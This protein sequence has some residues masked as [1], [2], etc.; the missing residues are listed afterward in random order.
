MSLIEKIK[1]DY[2][3]PPGWLLEEYL[4]ELEWS[5]AEFGRRCD[6]SSKT[7]CQ[8]IAGEAPIEPA[9]ALQFEKV[10]D[11]PAHVWLNMESNYRLFLARSREEEVLDS[12][13]VKTWYNSFPIKELEANRIIPKATDAIDGARFLLVFFGVGSVTAWKRKVASQ[14]AMTRHTKEF[15]SSN[16]AVSVWLRL[17]EIS[18]V[19]Q[20]CTP[21][22]VS[23]FR[24]V[25]KE[26]R[27]L[28]S[29]NAEE[30]IPRLLYLCNQAGVAFTIV[31]PLKATKMNGAAWWL[32]SDK[33]VIQ[34]S[35]R[36]K[37]ND[38]FWFTFFHEAAHILLHSKKGIFVDDDNRDGSEEENEADNWA[39]NFLIPEKDW[40]FFIAQESFSKSDIE[41]F[42]LKQGI[43]TG[44][45]L[46]RLQFEKHVPWK[47]WLNSALKLKFDFK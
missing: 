28:T 33:A 15:E 42:A 6:R 47:T 31:P 4:D 10:L 43:A 40:E 17:G 30:F 41:E 16:E 24:E 29:L 9:T 1:P 22:N 18:A 25:L 21:Y 34:Q 11:L 13:D 46:G 20:E 39:G 32:K 27:L 14:A 23:K 45:I 12:E 36:G 7:I 19:E 5:Q 3:A 44:I 37:S 26:I 2:V 38:K 35:L 8:I